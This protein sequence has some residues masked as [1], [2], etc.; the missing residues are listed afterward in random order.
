MN[1]HQQK[2]IRQA[3]VLRP[4]ASALTF[5]PDVC[6]QLAREDVDKHLE[7]RWKQILV[8]EKEEEEGGEEEEEE[9]ELELQKTRTRTLGWIYM[10]YSTK[11]KAGYTIFNEEGACAY[12][13]VCV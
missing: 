13:C 5:H 4:L 1:P 2:L 6:L 11:E 9:E 3:P 10:L 8:K 12:K 7:N